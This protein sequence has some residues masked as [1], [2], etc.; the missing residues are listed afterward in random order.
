MKIA[1]DPTRCRDLEHFRICNRLHDYLLWRLVLV[2]R[3]IDI[4]VPL[5]VFFR[6]HT[7]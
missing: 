1:A 3:V 7:C 5:S 4:E 6:P 2:R